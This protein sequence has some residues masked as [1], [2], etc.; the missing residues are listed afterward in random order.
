MHH[1]P[2]TSEQ[3]ARAQLESE[4]DPDGFRAQRESRLRA[5]YEY[6]YDRLGEDT[7]TK[8]Y[9]TYPDGTASPAD[10]TTRANR[11]PL[12]LKPRLRSRP[13]LTRRPIHDKK[14]LI[15]KLIAKNL[16]ASCLCWP[17]CRP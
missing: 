6:V 11:N 1:E 16:K 2:T 3:K 15:E 9:S 12:L 14:A 5:L 8:W 10:R 17:K 13:T 7:L 4:R